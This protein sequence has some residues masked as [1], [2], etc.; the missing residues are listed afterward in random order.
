MAY[1]TGKEGAMQPVLYTPYPQKIALIGNYVPRQCGIATFTSDLLNALAQE[2]P[3][4]EYSAVVINDI[5]EGYRYPSEVRFEIGQKVLAEYRLAA[6]FLNTNRVDVVCL[7]HEYGIFGGEN[8]AYILDLLTHLRMPL[9][10]TLHT[11]IQS[12]TPGQLNILKKIAHLSDR[13]VV[14]CRK[15]IEILREVY[16]VPD[17]KITLIPHGIPD[18]PFVDPNF[19]KDQYGVEGRKVILTFGLIS[20]GKGIETMIEALPEISRVHPEVVYIVL[21]A[22]HPQVKKRTGRGLPFRTATEGSRTQGGR[23]P[24]F[25]QPL[26]RTTRIM[27]I[28][29]G[30]RPLCHPLSQS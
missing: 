18:V 3:S 9:V 23:T 5:P 2:D 16:G 14:M 22:T 17:S 28:F 30:G 13:L 1:Y 6:D 27:R 24:S 29:G 15:A 4:G 8:G 20:P 25:S 21:G 10:T 11:V 26:R 19:Y 12:P 7:Q